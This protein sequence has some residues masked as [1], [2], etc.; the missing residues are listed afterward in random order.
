[1]KIRRIINKMSFWIKLKLG[2]LTTFHDNILEIVDSM[3]E[4]DDFVDDLCE[5]IDKHEINKDGSNNG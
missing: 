1:M 4:N 2:L 3:M 5:L